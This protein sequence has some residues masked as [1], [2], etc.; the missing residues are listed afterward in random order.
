MPDPGLREQRTTTRD[1]GPYGRLDIAERTDARSGSVL[2]R[3]HAPRVR[4]CV[5]LSP[6]TSADDPTMPTRAS[7]ELLIHSDQFAPAFALHD[8]RPL[9]VNNVVLTGPVRVTVE[10]AADFRPLRR[11]KT[12][13]P[14]WL[15][16][17]THRHA[18]AV[19]GALVETWRK[20]QDLDELTTAARRQAA[21]VYLATYTAQLSARRETAIRALGAVADTERRVTAL[22]ALLTA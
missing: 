4:G 1:L 21:Q 6:A 12:G 14:E 13:R 16:P 20:R 22:H 17:R 7:G 8:P 9:S 15:P 18:L 10:E 5:M 3:L 2:Y 11:G 19:L